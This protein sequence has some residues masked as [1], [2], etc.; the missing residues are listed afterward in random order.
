M[1]MKD[2]NASWPLVT[3]RCPSSTV[4]EGGD[5]GQSEGKEHTAGNWDLNCFVLN[6]TGKHSV[7]CYLRT[8]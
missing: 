8:P 7:K 1:P 2:R 5:P 6:S 4:A 3:G